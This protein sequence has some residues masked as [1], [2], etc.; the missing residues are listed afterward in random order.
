MK[1]FKFDKLPKNI[2][3]TK[4]KNI[5]KKIKLRDKNDYNRD[6]SPLKMAIDAIKIDTSKMTPLEV[7]MFAIKHIFEKKR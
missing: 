1:E 7:E 2:Q 3:A 5:Y 6:I 4:Y